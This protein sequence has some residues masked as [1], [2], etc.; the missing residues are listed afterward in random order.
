MRIDFT[1]F[2]ARGFSVFDLLLYQGRPI[3]YNGN[4]VGHADQV[5]LKT[6]GRVIITCEMDA[7]YAG[8]QLGAD[9]VLHD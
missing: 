6:D 8:K 1:L 4:V 9:L 3:T 7:C 5:D 2:P